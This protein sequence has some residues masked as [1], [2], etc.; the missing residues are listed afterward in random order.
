[1]R[2]TVMDGRLATNESRPW[3]RAQFGN[4]STGT[5]LGTFLVHEARVFS[6][7]VSADTQSQRLARGPHRFEDW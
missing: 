3:P 6:R 7:L 5:L 4:V 1:M 2:S